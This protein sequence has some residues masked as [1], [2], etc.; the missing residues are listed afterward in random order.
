MAIRV[1]FFAAHRGLRIT[2]RTHRWGDTWSEQRRT[3]VAHRY[4]CW[5]VV[6]L[7]SIQH[8]RRVLRR[9]VYI[10]PLHLL[11]AVSLSQLAKQAP[12][13]LLFPEIIRW[14]YRPSKFD[15]GCSGLNALSSIWPFSF[16]VT[17][18]RESPA[19]ALCL[20]TYLSAPSI[21]LPQ[22]KWGSGWA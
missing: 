15:H 22:W 18:G 5:I 17:G 20:Q 10:T 7:V 14:G 19:V 4:W 13:S 1:F 16:A 21:W 6:W 8:C 9:R 11:A 12:R 2:T 3:H